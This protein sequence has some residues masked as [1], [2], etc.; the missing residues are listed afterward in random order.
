MQIHLQD[1][2]FKMSNSINAGY[3]INQL[4]VLSCQNHWVK[5]VQLGPDAWVQN[6]IIASVPE[7]KVKT[8]ASA[9]VWP[10]ATSFQEL[11]RLA[12]APSAA[13]GKW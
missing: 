7:S 10:E 8:M 6:S 12:A 4:N 5:D 2:T 13:E 3:N 1:T 11:G 9:R